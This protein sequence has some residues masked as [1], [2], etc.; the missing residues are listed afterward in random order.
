MKVLTVFGTRPEAIKMA[1][2]VHA[3]AQDD[4]FESRVCVTAQHREM[5]DQVLRLFEIVPDYDLNIMKPGQGLSEITC[6]I[7]EGIKGVLEDFKPD[8]VL[9]HG[10]TTTTMATSLAAFYQR[11]PVGHVEAGLRTGNLYSPWPEEANRKLTGHLA[12]YHF[13][14]TEN[15]RQNLLRESLRDD[16]IFVTGN[17]VI[18]AL[19]WVRDR[20]MHNPELRTSL[21]QR[22]PF[23]DANKKLILVTGHR[24]ESFGG[25]FERICSAL[26]EIALQHPEVQ[27][28]YPVHLNP[29]VSEP[30]NRILKG[31]DNIIL[32]DPQDYLPFVYLMTR[33]YL[34][35][36][37]SGGIQEEA[38]SLGKPVLVMR[39]TTERPEAVDAGTVQ[40][41]GTDV[42]KIVDA[43]TR[44]LTDEGEYHAMSRAHNP[45]GDGHACQRIL[46]ALKNH[47]V[48]L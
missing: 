25:G 2:L 38:P 18:D 47:Q 6:R 40:L 16:H 39:D 15:S 30:V 20:I 32:I 35:L 44:L 8:V 21:D 31:I 46:E 26:A 34:I 5:L 36:T 13:A 45:Y 42:A 4:A 10:D 22:Y 27:V 23:L 43:V 1:P 37:D 41:V 33:S 17:T 12:M 11:I 28:V 48:T 29:N 19:L 7:L 3:L 24:R 9:V 14:P